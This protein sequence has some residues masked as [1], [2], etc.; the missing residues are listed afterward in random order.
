MGSK[1][2]STKPSGEVSS[3]NQPKPSTDLVFISASNPPKHLHPQKL[4]PIFL[5]RGITGPSDNDSVSSSSSD[6]DDKTKEID[7]QS[8]ES[9]SEIDSDYDSD[10][11]EVDPIERR[12]DRKNRLV[13]IRKDG[14]VGW[15]LHDSGY[16][17]EA[18]TR[19]GPYSSRFTYSKSSPGELRQFVKQRN[20][21]DPYPEGL[22]L[23]YFYLR[24]LDRADRAASFRFLD[25]PGEMRNAIY[26][27]LLLFLRCTHCPRIHDVC[28]TGILRTNKQV[29]KEALDILYGD[30][31]IRCMFRA[32][33]YDEDPKNFF[34]WIHIK[35]TRGHEKSMDHVFYGMSEIPHWFRRIQR[36]RVELHFCGGSIENAG[37]RL[38]TCLLNLASFLMD[39]HCLKKLEIHISDESNGEE[40]FDESEYDQDVVAG[41]E[42]T[43]YPLCRLHGVEHVEI[44][45]LSEATMNATISKMQKTKKSAFNTLVHFDNLM[46]A[47]K[48]YMKMCRTLNPYNF[49]HDVPEFHGGHLLQD[50]ERMCAELGDYEEMDEEYNP[51]EDAETEDNTR[52]QLEDL[53]DCVA[54]VKLANFEAAKKEFLTAR[55]DIAVYQSKSK[56]ILVDGKKEKVAG[57]G[58]RH[59]WEGRIDVEDELDFDEY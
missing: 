49:G 35:E 1:T 34:S 51:F 39:G 50:I 12:I 42:T 25:L 6:P 55:K 9:E 3:T 17:Q 45:G 33:G 5:G 13:K 36:L 11:V 22:T 57:Q 52:R 16:T 56:W 15:H 54:K 20:L 47:A 30:N 32:S 28:H 43:V 4:W 19:R 46:K 38:Q 23:K 53:R 48:A 44:T 18:W 24:L 27:E 37:F 2:S 10:D 41:F 21:T 58:L 7:D 8:A 29:C 26:R 59:N 31:D 40:D 14:T